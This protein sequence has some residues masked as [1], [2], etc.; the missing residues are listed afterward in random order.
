MN[1][2][3]LFETIQSEIDEILVSN[4]F[5]IDDV[6]NNIKLITIEHAIDYYYNK[7]SVEELIDIITEI[8]SVREAG[9][10][11]SLDHIIKHGNPRELLNFIEN[12]NIN[13][14]KIDYS[15][16]YEILHMIGGS[17]LMSYKTSNVDMFNK[18]KSIS[19]L[20]FSNDKF[21]TL[22]PNLYKQMVE[23]Y[24]GL[25]LSIPN[26]SASIVASTPVSVVPA[27]VAPAPVVSAPVV[28]STPA[29]VSSIPVP[30]IVDVAKKSNIDPQDHSIWWTLGKWAILISIIWIVFDRSK[31]ALMFVY[32]KYH[33]E[34]L[35]NF[36][37][38]NDYFSIKTT[39]RLLDYDYKFQ[40]CADYGRLKTPALLTYSQD[41]YFKVRVCFSK[42]IGSTFLYLMKMY[43]DYLKFKG[44]NLTNIRINAP[45]DLITIR[46]ERI[47]INIRDSL[48]QM[49]KIINVFLDEHYKQKLLI[50]FKLTISDNFDINRFEF[51][52]FK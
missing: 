5:N 50:L 14:S 34:K 31:N 51:D 16:A 26:A 15:R 52:D 40:T 21:E 30:D 39:N 23:I 11:N 37:K 3:N 22:D 47:N 44:I 48:F 2:I 9:F 29:S 20:V 32:Y 33:I 45:K 46:D 27:S 41:E 35:L 42:Y 8:G 25:N 18:L 19:D 7:A 12:N 4:N 17:S 43:K 13:Y 1:N 24:K 49:D 6:Y 28:A 38:R 36:F 10:L